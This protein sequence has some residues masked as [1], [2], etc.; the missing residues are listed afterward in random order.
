[1]KNLLTLLF[2]LGSYLSFAQTNITAMEYYLDSDPGVGNG[3]A[4]VISTGN[5]IDET[6]TIPNASLPE[7]FHKLVIRVQDENLDWSVQETKFFLVAASDPQ[8]T[9]NVVSGEYYLDDDPGIG[10]GTAITLSPN[11][12]IDSYFTIA[13]SNLTQGFHNLV[14]RLQDADGEWSVQESRTIFAANANPMV[15]A[16]VIAAE[17]FL[18]SDPGIGNATSISITGGTEVDFSFVIPG[19]DF[20][21]GFHVIGLRTQ[22]ENGQWSMLEYI[23]LYAVKSDANTKSDVVSAEYYVDDDPGIGNGTSVSLSASENVDFSF[24]V[25]Q[26]LLTE[27]FHNL[28]I[29]T[30]DSNGQWGMQESIAVYASNANPLGTTLISEIE[31]F[32]DDDPGIGSGTSIDIVDVVVFDEQLMAT[33]NGLDPGMHNITFRVQDER[34]VWSQIEKRNFL[35]DP[36]ISN[37]ISSGIA[38]NIVSYEYFMDVDPGIGQ[39]TEVSVVPAS[40]IDE[41]FSVTTGA[42]SEGVHYLGVRL[43]SEIGL[44]GLTE[45]SEFSVCQGATIDFSAITVCIGSTTQFVDASTGVLEGDVYSWDFDDDGTEDANTVGNVEHTY[46]EI[47]TYTVRLTISNGN[48]SSNGTIEVTVADFPTVV[49]E[50]TSQEICLGDLVTLS[51]TGAN[52][53]V[54][55]NNAVDGVAFSPL[56]TTTYSVIGTD[57]HGCES[58]DEITITV[59]AV[60]QPVISIDSDNGRQIVMSSSSESGNQW[61]EADEE[62]LGETGQ[63]ITVERTYYFG[64]QYTVEVT[65]GDCSASSEIADLGVL[66]ANES[67][68]A[69]E[70][71]MW[72]NPVNQELTIS[73]NGKILKSKEISIFNLSGATVLHQTMSV[74]LHQLTLDL[75]HVGSGVYLLFIEG[76][77]KHYKLFKN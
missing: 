21:E 26:S 39:A 55:D 34:G 23:S 61:Y 66:G 42:L 62:L 37:D 75:S 46:A 57:V 31:Y 43:I 59:N 3:V 47:G 63:L 67:L 38:S 40:S 35:V 56:E 54:W 9:A 13:G 72:P 53:Y 19:D 65:E 4:V 14:I 20:I 16:E 12:E 5:T 17:Y 69:S 1:M 25:D 15:S 52:D 32:I 28:V 49:A 51:G 24:T 29:R 27:G 7:G 77:N 50:S 6:F 68:N 8:V 30:Q 71:A 60:E 36:F 41:D 76:D 70:M 73:F 22:D 44:A 18:D 2:L 11:T 45:V 10:N 64:G 58:M 48:C 33:T 74:G